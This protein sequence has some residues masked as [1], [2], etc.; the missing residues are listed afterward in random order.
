MIGFILYSIVLILVT[1]IINHA[2]L[3]HN[4]HRNEQK[5]KEFRRMNIRLR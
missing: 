2:I 4:R 1:L 3:E 5:D